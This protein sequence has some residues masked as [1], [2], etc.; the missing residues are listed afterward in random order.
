MLFAKNDPTSNI[1]ALGLWPSSSPFLGV[2]I[3]GV[4]LTHQN[5]NQ[6]DLPLTATEL[7]FVNEA[8]K[9]VDED[10]APA[11]SY[12]HAMRNG[13]LN[14]PDSTA[15]ARANNW[16]SSHLSN[17]Q[18]LLCECNEESRDEALWQFGL[19]LHTIQDSTSPAH[20][21]RHHRRGAITFRPWYGLDGP[22]A[23][24]KAVR[25][26]LRENF[27]PGEYGQSSRL[28]DATKDMWKYFRCKTGAPPLP[29]NF[30]TYGVD[31]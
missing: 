1:D 22:I 2:L 25:H 3:G 5:A 7:F 20:N 6:R 30:F 29:A 18:T 15:R 31:P 19:A 14:E 11:Q 24:A 21:G 17:A 10:Q 8:S 16:V 13:A 26:V 12:E 28:D 23:W 9:F 4:P 27:D